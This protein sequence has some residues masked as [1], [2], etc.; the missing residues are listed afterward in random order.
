MPFVITTSAH[1]RL[2]ADGAP[3]GVVSQAAA[4]AEAGIDLAIVDLPVPHKPSV[5]ELRAAAPV[6]LR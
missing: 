2:G 6:P 4:F 3:A 5:L 1:L